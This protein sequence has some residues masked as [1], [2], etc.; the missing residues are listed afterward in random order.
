MDPRPDHPRIPGVAAPPRR[1][2]DLPGLAESHPRPSRL[3]HRETAVRNLAQRGNRG[4]APTQTEPAQVTAALVILIVFL[5][6][7]AAAWISAEVRCADC[8]RSLRQTEREVQGLKDDLW[9]RDRMNVRTVE[10]P[11]EGLP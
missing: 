7:A 9:R 5:I 1:N 8:N 2:A 3:H 6:G 10:P 4:R 11:P